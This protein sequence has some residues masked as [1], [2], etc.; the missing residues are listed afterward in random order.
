MVG[1]GGTGVAV[2]D[3]V[4]VAGDV[5][6]VVKVGFPGRVVVTGEVGLGLG[7]PVSVTVFVGIEV[8]VTAKATRRPP[9]INANAMLPKTITLEKTATKTA[10]RILRMSFIPGFLHAHRWEELLARRVV[11]Y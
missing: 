4:K 1:D 3:G 7:V 8:G 10:C 2:G 5:G 11:E 6:E 9:S